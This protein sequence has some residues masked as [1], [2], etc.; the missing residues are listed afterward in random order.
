MLSI[1]VLVTRGTF[2]RR[3]RIDDDARVVALAGRSGAGK[4]S[5]LH[6]VAGLVRPSEG[7]IA[8]DG[9]V[10]F[11]SAAGIDV[12]VHARHVGYVFQDGR[13]FPHLD[14]R[15]NLRYARRRDGAARFAFDDVVAL[16]GI[17][18]LLARRTTHLSGG[19][20]Q[21]VAIGRA[22]LS[23]PRVLLLDEPMASLDAERREELIPY[24][25]RVRDE[26]A[27]PILYVSHSIDEVRRLT[28]AVHA[29]D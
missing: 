2:R 7:R 20:V 22:L 11:D 13:L 12:P 28:A 27:L 6:A 21:R 29:I 4:S 1:D 10:L 14:V 16:L 19:E 23:Q 25:Q 8:I 24:L 17:G 18:D 5:V 15:G 26:T 9:R 3:V